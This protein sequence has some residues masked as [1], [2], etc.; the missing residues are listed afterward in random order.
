MWGKQ[1]FTLIEMVV[2]LIIIAI[3]TVFSLPNFTAPSEQARSL[4]AKNNLL[5]IYTA[6]KS[7]YNNNNK[8]CLG[9]GGSPTNCADTLAD[10]NT[11]LSLNIQD[12]GTYTYECD[13]GVTVANVNSCTATRTNPSGA[14]VITL[15]LDKPVQPSGA[16]LNPTCTAP[17]HSNWCPI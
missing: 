10:I 4:N 3:A 8:Y 14:V 6:E 13:F 12:D 7:Y 2:V 11:N 15:T 17:S 16:Y 5:A 1:G 9:T